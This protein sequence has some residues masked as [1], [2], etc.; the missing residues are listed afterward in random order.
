MDI[1]GVVCRLQEVSDMSMRRENYHVDEKPTDL[2]SAALSFVVV[3]IF[4][5][6]FWE[7]GAARL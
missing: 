4:I 5:F 1:A 6:V 3:C 7:N 2:S